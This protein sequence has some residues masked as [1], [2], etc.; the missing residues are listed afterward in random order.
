MASLIG[1]TL[2]KQLCGVKFNISCC[3]GAAVTLFGKDTHTA[4]PAG[5]AG[6]PGTAGSAQH[7][8]LGAANQGPNIV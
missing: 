4:P 8:S 1:L 5:P 2:A 3:K 6:M 7:N